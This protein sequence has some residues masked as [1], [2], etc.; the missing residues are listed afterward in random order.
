[1]TT[2]QH[3]HITHVNF[4]LSAWHNSYDKLP[5]RMTTLSYFVRVLRANDLFRAV[6]P[7][8]CQTD[9]LW[10]KKNYFYSG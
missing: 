8:R 1:M 5:R 2:R 3:L 7:L 4:I 6:L 9:M 10:S